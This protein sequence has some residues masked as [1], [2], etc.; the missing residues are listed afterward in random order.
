[1]FEQELELE[2]KESSVL[3]L[4]LIV[5]F[6][7][8]IV[9]FAG[10]YVVEMRKVLPVEEASKIVAKMLQDQGPAKVSFYT[11]QVNGS[12][13]DNAKDPQYRL[14]EK[15]E[16]IK[17]G[18]PTG[19]YGMT[20]PVELT[21]KGEDMLKQIVGVTQKKT[22]NGTLRYAVPL[23]TRKLL[24]VTDVKM[25]NPNRATVNVTWTWETNALGELFDAAGPLVQSFSAWERVAL[26]E[27]GGAAFYHR[28]PTKVVVALSKLDNTWQ[29]A[30]E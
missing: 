11:G 21:P 19:A 26:I 7:V 23:A 29:I 30:T 15:G 4:L 13:E 28:P 5:A 1:M 27:K 24:S 20:I 10:Y 3:P 9:G 18:K 6:I 8:G 2:K 22:D 14:L 16:V 12:I 25:I 17:L